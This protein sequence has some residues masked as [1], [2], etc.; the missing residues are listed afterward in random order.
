[1]SSRLR[2]SPGLPLLVT[3][4]AG[5]RARGVCLQ[6]DLA[7]RHMRDG[8]AVLEARDV[9]E[10]A[11]LCDGWLRALSLPALEREELVR[12]AIRELLETFEREG[13]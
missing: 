1:L 6:F 12:R 4:F 5:G 9:A 7:G 8:Y 11:G 3:E 2:T 10:L 13:L